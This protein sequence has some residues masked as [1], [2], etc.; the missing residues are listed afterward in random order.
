MDDS[1]GKRFVFKDGK[2]VEGKAGPEQLPEHMRALPSSFITK[3]EAEGDKVHEL[4]PPHIVEALVKDLTEKEQPKPTLDGLP[5]A[6]QALSASMAPLGAVVPLNQRRIDVVR[7][8]IIRSRIDRLC[9]EAEAGTIK[10]EDALKNVDHVWFPEDN[11]NKYELRKGLP[12]PNSMRPKRLHN[13]RLELDIMNW[14]QSV[15]DALEALGHKPPNVKEMITNAR[16]KAS[17]IAEISREES[18]IW[19]PR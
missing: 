18:A 10:L 12:P 14:P 9:K 7:F 5:L 15:I 16:R 17:V 11:V 4:D 19:T 2:F 13:Y 3:H 8:R 6:V 1:K